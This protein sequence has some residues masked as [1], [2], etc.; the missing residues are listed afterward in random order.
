MPGEFEFL[1]QHRGQHYTFSRCELCS[2]RAGF[3]IWAGM[4]RTRGQESGC[5]SKDRNPTSTLSPPRIS[6]PTLPGPATS[7][8]R[9]AV[10]ST[11][12]HRG[13]ALPGPQ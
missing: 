12:V 8:L 11:P 9:A 7:P 2:G 6:L 4:E 5:T 13:S 10:S 3:P 1:L